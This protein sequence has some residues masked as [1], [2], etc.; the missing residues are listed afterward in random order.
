MSRKATRKRKPHTA[1]SVQLIFSTFLISIS[2]VKIVGHIAHNCKN[3]FH[4]LHLF[5]CMILVH[6]PAGMAHELLCKQSLCHRTM[7]E[8]EQTDAVNQQ[9]QHQPFYA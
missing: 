2:I 1:V 8:V 6:P 9:E 7:R 5:L 4:F 3:Y